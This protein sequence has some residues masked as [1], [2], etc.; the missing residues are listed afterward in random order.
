MDR[1]D[2]KA[3]E[4]DFTETQCRDIIP[5]GGEMMKK[6]THMQRNIIISGIIASTFLMG[7]IY[8]WYQ[9]TSK[10]NNVN[11]NVKLANISPEFASDNRSLDL[12]DDL[13]KFQKLSDE[14][15]RIQDNNKLTN[16]SKQILEESK[17]LTEK[18]KLKNGEIVKNINKLELYINILEF[19]K[20]A[21]SNIDQE[22]LNNLY[23][24][25][26]NEILEYNLEY[27]KVLENQL[28][29]IIN[30]YKDLQS[31]ITQILKLGTLNN[32]TLYIDESITTFDNINFK[33]LEKFPYVKSLEMLF[34]KTNIL[35]NNKALIE[36]HKLI[37]D[38]EKF[39]IF[40]KTNYIQVK[41]IKTAKDAEN[42]T[43]VYKEHEGYELDMDSIVEKVEIN[44]QIVNQSAYVKKSKNVHVHI[45]AKYKKT[46]RKE[47]NDN[48]IRENIE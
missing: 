41:N 40:D 12:E 11:V 7:G 21:Y 13:R 48:E 31:L 29:T 32:N 38:L 16:K 47:K 43:L 17:I 36:K 4:V 44:N 1:L 23:N 20:T 6:K 33:T 22:K 15:V 39:S 26:T 10:W 27:D 8:L 30:D 37:S 18:Y 42:M 3:M 28:S 2:K 45:I 19:Q 35:N 25:L 24:Q 5:I 9:K 46:E 14:I 34:N